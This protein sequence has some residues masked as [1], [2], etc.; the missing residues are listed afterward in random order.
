MQI[1]F[2][3]RKSLASGDIEVTTQILGTV[4]EIK[5]I[6]NFTH[7]IESLRDK[8]QFAFNNVAQPSKE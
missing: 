6:G 3:E 8:L 5:I 1:N 2:S 4:E 7:T